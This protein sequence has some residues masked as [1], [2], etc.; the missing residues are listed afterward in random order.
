MLNVKKDQELTDDYLMTSWDYNPLAFCDF[1][2][3]FKY[4]TPGQRIMCFWLDQVN[5][6]HWFLEL[7][8]KQDL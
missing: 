1:A 7:A 6:I 8:P 5:D 4:W 2:F 3:S